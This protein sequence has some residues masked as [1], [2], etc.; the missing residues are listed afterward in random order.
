[1]PRA[2]DRDATRRGLG[3]SAVNNLRRRQSFEVGHRRQA[4]ASRVAKH[5]ERGAGGVAVAENIHQ[6]ERDGRG[7]VVTRCVGKV[8]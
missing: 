3:R 5:I 8:Q 6:F 7:M 4:P 1:M 2:M